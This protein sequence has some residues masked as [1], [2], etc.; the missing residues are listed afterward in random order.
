MPPVTIDE[1]L[2]RK[3]GLCARICQK[4][5]AEEEKGTVP[6]VA[7]GEFCNSCGH[8]LLV[9]PSGAIRL[10]GFAAASLHETSKGLLPS[11]DQVRELIV[12]RRSVQ[13]FQGKSVEKELIEKVIDAASHAPSAKNTQSTHYIVVQDRDLLKSIASLTAGWLA[14][15]AK[16]LRNPLWR[17]LYLL[18][19]SATKADVAR[20]TGQFELISKKMG[21]GKDLVLFDCPALILFH[22]DKKIR[23]AQVNANL[24]QQNAA[25]TVDALGLGGFYTGYVVLACTHEDAIPRLLGL[26]EKHAVFAGLAFGYPQVRF[27]RWIDRNPPKIKWM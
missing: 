9:C 23:F 15:S 27:T 25:L 4:V 12:S 11:Y 8:C 5:F 26:P 7:H 21:E 10:A 24:A 16:R 19:G 2:C 22:G 13:T 17:R 1:N 18:G 3:D 14:K 6:V 20:W